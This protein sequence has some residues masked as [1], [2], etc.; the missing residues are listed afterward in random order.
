MS[1][2]SLLQDEFRI[3]AVVNIVLTKPDG[4]PKTVR[5][6]S[7]HAPGPATGMPALLNYCFQEILKG[8]I[9][10]FIGDFNMTGLDEDTKKVSLPMTLFRTGGSTTYTKTGPVAHEEG[11]DLVYANPTTI[12]APKTL[13]VMEEASS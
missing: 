13:V 5:V 1:K 4:A 7:W 11:L 12:R 6:A 8:H 10:L 9:D 2:L 3:P